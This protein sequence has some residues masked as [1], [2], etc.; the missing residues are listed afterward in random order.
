MIHMGGQER[1]LDGHLPALV[2]RY[3]GERLLPHEPRAPGRPIPEE[4]DRLLVKLVE[5]PPGVDSVLVGDHNRSSFA[6]KNP[7]PGT[8][9]C[10]RAA[11]I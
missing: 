8:A 5:V 10:K 11:R 2:E 1:I 4:V 6:P 3:L 7:L 9:R